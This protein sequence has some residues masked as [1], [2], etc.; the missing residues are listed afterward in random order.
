MLSSQQTEVLQEIANIG[1][2]Q[3]GAAIGKVLNR[4]VTLSI[5]R[6]HFLQRPEVLA[7]LEGML[8]DGVV[9]AVRQT[10]H[11]STRGEA[12]AVF[13]E[14]RCG[15]LA[16]LMGYVMPLDNASEVELLLDVSN[17]LISGCL[18]GIAMEI[19]APIRFSA[20]SLLA[21]HVPV[22]SLIG[23]GRDNWHEGILVEVHFTVQERSFAC[24]IV[25][26][27]PGEELAAFGSALDSYAE[28]YQ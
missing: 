22:R 17:M 25:I 14:A 7:T 9:S 5:P 23:T 3:A 28:A 15:D 10:F 19:K 4:Y 26:L 24:N 18:S 2:G 21:E 20:P 8:G 6:V 11:G 16:D 12:V 13:D 27:I 1:M